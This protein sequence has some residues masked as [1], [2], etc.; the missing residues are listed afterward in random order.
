MSKRWFGGV[1]ISLCFAS[2]CSRPTHGSAPSATCVIAE[3]LEAAHIREDSDGGE[4]IVPNGVAMCA[5]HH[6]A[7]D[8]A[9][10]GIRPDYVIEIR[11][12]ILEEI[13]GPL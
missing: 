7:F 13:D 4:P 11:Q 10:L 1:F 12:D 6:K 9:V 5:I 8:N 2:G 3:L